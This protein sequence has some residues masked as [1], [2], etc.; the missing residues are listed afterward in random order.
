MD[1]TEDSPPIDHIPANRG[2][3]DALH[4]KGLISADAR[5]HALDLLNP[6]DQWGVWIERLLATCGATLVLSGLI[7]FFAFNW[8]AIP[9]FAKL[10]GLEVLMAGCVALACWRGL[11]R[12]SGQLLLLA[13][14]VLL[15]IFMAVYGQIYQTGAD[16]WQLFFNWALLGL[17]WVIVSRFA[18]L[19]ALWI[20][21]ADLALVLWWQQGINVLWSNR[22]YIYALVAALNG[23]LLLLGEY[24][25]QR[26]L[27]WLQ[28]PWP[29]LLLLASVAGAM[30]PPSLAWIF[31]SNPNNAESLMMGLSVLVH[32]GL[33]A[34][35]RY[36]LKNILGVAC[37]VLS[38][39]IVAESA[40]IRLILEM[41]DDA[42]GFFM[43]TLT[44]IGLFALMLQFLRHTAG[45][46]SHE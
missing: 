29:R 46:L 25:A 13:G 45:E 5:L 32:I 15:G 20:V 18:A 33:F 28:K 44:T 9:D 8:R 4:Y 38:A 19:W 23:S 31:D 22:L 41:N 21:V 40:V 3:V 26:G 17:V 30:V 24:Y 39:S 1:T 27:P 42:A 14:F 7:Y 6:R 36:V 10:G 43:I 35:Y 2:L 12:L 11:Q 37:V 16:A 34:A